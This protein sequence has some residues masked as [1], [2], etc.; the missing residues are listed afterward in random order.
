MIGQILAQ[1]LFSHY[2]GD[3][4]TFY[5]Q[6]FCYLRI[7]QSVCLTDLSLTTMNEVV[8]PF[9]VRSQINFVDFTPKNP[10]RQCF[11]IP[12]NIVYYIS[13]NGAPIVYQKLIQC[14]KHFLKKQNFSI[15]DC[16]NE[17]KIIV[18]QGFVVEMDSFKLGIIGEHLF[19]RGNPRFSDIFPKLC[20]VKVEEIHLRGHSLKYNEFL[21]LTSWEKLKTFKFSSTSDKSSINHADGTLVKLVDILRQLPLIECFAL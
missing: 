10:A 6:I 7:F 5:T 17:G 16:F 1:C 8:F 20:F 2:R 21:Y 19:L 11:S 9:Y 4:Y 12:G 14:C 15:V 18:K 13:K 3:A